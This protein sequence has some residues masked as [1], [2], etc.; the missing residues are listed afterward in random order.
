MRAL[1]KEIQ[2]AKAAP[3]GQLGVRA[4]VVD[5]DRHTSRILGVF[6]GQVSYII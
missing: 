1:E 5:K 3:E 4:L 2:L 6:T